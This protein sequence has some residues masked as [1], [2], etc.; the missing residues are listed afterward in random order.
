MM[1]RR[2]ISVLFLF[3]SLVALSA[4]AEESVARVYKN[5]RDGVVDRDGQLILPI[6]FED[7]YPYYTHQNGKEVV[8]FW[9]TYVP[10][11]ILKRPAMLFD[12]N[13]KKLCEPVYRFCDD[14]V[15]GMR[16]G[17]F[18]SEDAVYAARENEKGE[19]LGEIIYT[20]GVIISTGFPFDA[21]VFCG[22]NLVKILRN[23]KKVLWNLGRREVER[24]PSRKD[25]FNNRY[26]VKGWNLAWSED[27]HPHRKVA[28]YNARIERNEEDKWWYV[29]NKTGL[30]LT[31]EKYDGLQFGDWLNWWDGVF[32][33]KLN[34]KWGLFKLDGTVVL[35]PEYDGFDDE[36]IM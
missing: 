16:A 31:K 13:G 17:G 9:A 3:T 18:I 23:G 11:H 36:P 24:A 10:N 5:G 2:L 12:R 19:E 35:P 22:T 34:G 29:D 25:K 32:P 15:M 21:P 33:A 26:E 30:P 28:K 4:I 20:D 8:F 27:M 14:S 1:T 7:I 6:E